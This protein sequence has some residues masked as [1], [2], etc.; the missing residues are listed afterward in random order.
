MKARFPDLNVQRKSLPAICSRGRQK[1]ELRKLRAEHELKSSRKVAEDAADPVRQEE[2]D[3][4]GKRLETLGGE[5]ESIRQGQE[6][7]EKH[8]AFL[9]SV[10][11]VKDAEIEGLKKQLKD[12]KQKVSLF[13]KHLRAASDEKLELQRLLC[14]ETEE[15]ETQ[16]TQGAEEA[17][18]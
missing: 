10:V 11:E 13:G 9:E 17:E 4:L 5:N 2:I 18:G 7:A 12:E 6:E 15:D 3:E 16:D 14:G 1:R 8:V